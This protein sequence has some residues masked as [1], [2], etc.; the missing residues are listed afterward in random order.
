M[1]MWGKDYKALEKAN[2]YVYD[3]LKDMDDEFFGNLMCTSRW[4]SYD[5]PLFI[6]YLE[7]YD[8]CRNE[9][10]KQMKVIDDVLNLSKQSREV[11]SLIQNLSILY[12]LL[13]VCNLEG[14]MAI[15]EEEKA[16]IKAFNLE[17]QK[18]KDIVI[19]QVFLLLLE[20]TSIRNKENKLFE[21]YVESND[22][23][24]GVFK[25]LFSKFGSFSYKFLVDYD[26]LY[27][28]KYFTEIIPDYFYFYKIQMQ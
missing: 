10:F 3:L 12:N 16:R 11:C 25:E 13:N 27:Y 4:Y 5:D 14:I 1:L 20:N 6:Q 7:I 2:N 18:Y 17:F 26:T 28:E 15:S 19:K 24:K 22:E 8:E 9:G 23:I 21:L